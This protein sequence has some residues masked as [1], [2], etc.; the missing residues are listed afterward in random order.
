MEAVAP[1]AAAAPATAE[2]TAPAESAAGR[3][4]QQPQWSL[5]SVMLSGIES[6]GRA[7]KVSGAVVER[8]NLEAQAALAQRRV[9]P[10]RHHLARLP[11]LSPDVLGL[12]Y[13]C[14]TT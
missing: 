2:P 6:M 11:V 4:A 1:R 7:V 5:A 3:G 10:L 12:V 13:V 14:V 8:V 9:R